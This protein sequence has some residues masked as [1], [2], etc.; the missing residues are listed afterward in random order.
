MRVRRVVGVVLVVVLATGLSA[1]CQ[2]AEPKPKMPRV[3][4]SA[5][6]APAESSPPES[7][8]A[9]EFIRRWQAAGD[10]MQVSGETDKYRA[11]GPNC[12][13]CTGFADA[14]AQIYANGVQAPS[15]SR[16]W[17]E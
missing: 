15:S 16:G 9:E 1:G 12:K 7:E 6:P 10:E 3:T 8:S 11:L 4:E 14:V 17:S 2:S 13:P 5:S